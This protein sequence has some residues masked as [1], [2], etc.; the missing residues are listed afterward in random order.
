MPSEEG[1]GLEAC[2]YA[3]AHVISFFSRLT[4][5]CC[6]FN[7]NG[8]DKQA[9]SH[10]IRR[11]NLVTNQRMQMDLNYSWLLV[12]NL[13][14]IFISAF[15]NAFKLGCDSFYCAFYILPGMAFSSTI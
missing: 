10:L 11:V 14:F 15:R 1:T 8:S 5:L 6:C 9:E 2:V 3:F 12:K 7:I 13:P 4:M